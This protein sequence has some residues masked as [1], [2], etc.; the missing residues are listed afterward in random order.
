[1]GT[2]NYL[3]T[4]N[5]D[6]REALETVAEAIQTGSSYWALEARVYDLST[7]GTNPFG[8]DIRPWE[9]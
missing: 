6:L 5:Q 4:L 1:M 2:D 8:F 9:F 7:V 3:T